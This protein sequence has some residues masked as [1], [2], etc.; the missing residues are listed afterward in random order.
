MSWM[1]FLSVNRRYINSH[2][3]Y[4]TYQRDKIYIERTF[5]LPNDKLSVYKN[6]VNRGIYNFNDNRTTQC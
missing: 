1:H 3:D 4:E 5:V 6:L 2:I